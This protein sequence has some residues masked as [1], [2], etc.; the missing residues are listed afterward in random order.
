VRAGYK[1]GL[2]PTSYVK[3]SAPTLSPIAPQTT[4]PSGRPSSA[5][6]NSGSSVGT[7]NTGK[8]KGP[9]VAPKRGAKRLKYVEALYPY[10][11]RD[12][13]EHDMEVGE[14]FVLVKEDS[15]DGWAEVEKGGMTKMVP[16][17]YVQVV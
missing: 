11:A 16:A 17:S 12:E 14:R 2:V 4:G 8:K 6:S 1:E 5:Y 7:A 15:G 9:A 10:S 3:F 13:N